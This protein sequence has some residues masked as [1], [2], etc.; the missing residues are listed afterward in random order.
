MWLRLF[1]LNNCF[2]DKSQVHLGLKYRG[3]WYAITHFNNQ[4][5]VKIPKYFLRM[6]E[7]SSKDEYLKRITGSAP[8]RISSTN[9]FIHSRVLDHYDK[10]KLDSLTNKRKRYARKTQNGDK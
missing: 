5:G 6:R 1:K 3:K 4:V 2:N 10:F 8:N 9:M 7:K